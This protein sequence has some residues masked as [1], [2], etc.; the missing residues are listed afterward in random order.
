M[1]YL[2]NHDETR[3]LVECGDDAAKAAA[4]ALFT[5]PGIPMLYGGQELGQRG[6]RDPLAWD[7]A[8]EEIRDHYDDLLALR[9]AHPVLGSAG[10]L[11]RVEYDTAGTADA[12][13]VV[14]FARES[15]AEE[16]VVLLNFGTEP[17]VVGIDETVDATDLVAGGGRGADRRGRRGL[18]GHGLTDRP[19]R[20]TPPRRPIALPAPRRKRTVTTGF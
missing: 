2:E 19:G 15:E 10:D 18:R 1:L 20:R 9:E 3:Y 8:R 5:L 4:G 16:Y 17:A 6:N 12:D 14:A 13:D 7:H 11:A